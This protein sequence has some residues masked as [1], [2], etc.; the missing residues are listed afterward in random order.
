VS[1]CANIKSEAIAALEI[2]EP[3]I[4]MNTTSLNPCLNISGPRRAVEAEKYT[5]FILTG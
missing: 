1:A 3:V 5:L 2:S 4:A